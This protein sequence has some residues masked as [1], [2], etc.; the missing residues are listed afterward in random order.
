MIWLFGHP[1]Q[2]FDRC[3]LAVIDWAFAIAKTTISAI[4]AVAAEPSKKGSF[5]KLFKK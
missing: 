4:F 2:A 3:F 1:E 5:S